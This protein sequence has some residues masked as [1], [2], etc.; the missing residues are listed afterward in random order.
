MPQQLVV[1]MMKAPRCGEVKTR[2]AP[3]LSK[4]DAASLAACFAQD[5][6]RNARHVVR[7]V[8]IA[9][10][11]V[12]ARTDLDVILPS[13]LLWFEQD[14]NNLGDRSRLLTISIIQ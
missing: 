5:T 8:L 6:V 14:G 13:D 12:G 10:A 2:L 3:P 1:V 11:P 7:D 4:T 9:Y